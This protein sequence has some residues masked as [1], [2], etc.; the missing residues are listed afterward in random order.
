M[1]RLKTVKEFN[2][3][4]K[5]LSYHGVQHTVKL[6]PELQEVHIAVEDKTGF[7]DTT[8]IFDLTIAN[9]GIEAL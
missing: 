4:V 7:F 8:F 9:K 6:V 2:E 1:I 5:S 3:F